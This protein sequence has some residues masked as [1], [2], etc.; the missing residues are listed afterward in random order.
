MSST[1]VYPS[2]LVKVGIGKESTFGTAVAPAAGLAVAA[3]G[4]SDKHATIV[5]TGWRQSTAAS[6]GHQPGP[7][8]S[9]VSLGGPAFVDALGWP[10]AGVLGDHTVTGTTAPYTHTLALLNSGSMQPSSYTVTLDDPVGALAYPGCRWSGFT[11]TANADGLLTWGGTLAGLNPGAGSV[12]PA[13]AVVLPMPGWSGVVT[14]GGS[15]ESRVLDLSVS[16]TRQLTAKRNT[17]GQQTPNNIQAGAL[18]VSGQATLLIH[19]DNYRSSL[20]NASSLAIDATW[21]Q[22][23]GAASQQITLHSSACV[24][25]AASRAYVGD[26]VEVQLGWTADANTTDAGASGGKSPIKATLIN[27]VGA[28]LY[29]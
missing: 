29:T 8:D 21:S 2:R 22:G 27:A 6:Y 9:A 19:N 24:L 17:N 26:W 15:V 18:A 7:L 4:V 13:P 1:L 20:L 25:D 12:P 28:G 14:I 23:A 5:D 10:L 3:P 11:L 16:I